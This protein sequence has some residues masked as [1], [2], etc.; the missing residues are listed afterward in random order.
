MNAE[1]VLI[2]DGD[3][4]YPAEVTKTYTD[5]DVQVQVYIFNDAIRREMGSSVAASKIV[6]K[7]T[8]PREG[9]GTRQVAVQYFWNQEW[10]YT[11]D[12]TEFEAYY[13]VPISAS[14]NR[15]IEIKHIRFP[16]PVPR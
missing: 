3:Y 13:T 8:Q 6:A 9:W 4:M 15:S 16:M 7:R 5:S 12:A 2:E 1:I 11:E 14:E 10:I